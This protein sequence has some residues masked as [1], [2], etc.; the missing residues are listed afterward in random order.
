MIRVLI[1]IGEQGVEAIVNLDEYEKD[2]KKVMIEK[3]SDP[4]PQPGDHI[5]KI[6][7]VLGALSI[8]FRLNCHRKIKS[9]IIELPFK[10]DDEVWNMSEN[11]HFL[12]LV[13]EKGVEVNF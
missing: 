1:A 9:Y 10:S 13:K 8:R 4:N 11:H 3:L 12:N 2:R 6:N 7:K 5:P